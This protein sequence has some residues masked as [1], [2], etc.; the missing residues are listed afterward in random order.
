MNKHMKIVV[1]GEIFGP[2]R[3]MMATD[4]PVDSLACGFGPLWN[5]LKY[6]VRSARPR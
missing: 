6:I 1:I 4:Y 5:V 3:C 2:D